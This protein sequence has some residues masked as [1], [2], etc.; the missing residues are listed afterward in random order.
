MLEVVING[1]FLTFTPYLVHPNKL[2]PDAKLA[3]TGT[4]VPYALVNENDEVVARLLEFIL[5]LATELTFNKANVTV[6]LQSI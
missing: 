4:T 1:L 6:I 5:P 3:V 2:L